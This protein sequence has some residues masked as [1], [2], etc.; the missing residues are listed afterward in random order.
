MDFVDRC[1]RAFEKFKAVC[2]DPDRHAIGVYRDLLTQV[3][4]TDYGNA[5]MIT[6]TT[7]PGEFRQRVPIKT[8]T[9]FEPYIDQI[10][11]GRRKVL[12]VD[13][14]IA[15]YTTSG[16]TGRPKRVPA[17]RHLRQ[18]YRGPALECQW[19]LYFTQLGIQ[20][21]EPTLVVDFSWDRHAVADVEGQ[22]IPEYSI[23]KRPSSL[24]GGDWTPPWYDDSGFVT[25][26]GETHVDGEIRR[27]VDALRKNP[28][29]LVAVNPSRLIHDTMYIVN[30][31]RR[32]AEALGDGQD[33]DRARAAL[34][35]IDG[36]PDA[37]SVLFPRLRMIVSWLSASA[38]L[39]SGTL[40]QLF[41]GARL[42]PFSTT[43][44]E[45]IVTL[46]V[47]GEPGSPLAVNQ[48]WYEFVPWKDLNSD[49]PVPPHDPTLC[50]D[51]LE[52]GQQYRLIM[53]QATGL[54]RYDTGDAYRVTGWFG[55]SPRLEF[56]GRVGSTSSMTGEKLTEGCI[57]AAVRSVTAVEG[58]ERFAMF[59]EPP[60]A[61]PPPVEPY[62]ILAIERALI[63]T[64]LTPAEFATRVDRALGDQN[65]EY[66]G[67]R[68][69]DEKTVIRLGRMRVLPV[70]DGAFA[71]FREELTSTGQVSPTQ[72]KHRVLHPRRS[73][74]TPEPPLQGWLFER[75]LPDIV[76]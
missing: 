3:A 49:E 32:I 25:P 33:A 42:M 18:R 6:L 73:I 56:V 63:P 48:G 15:F 69:G 62:Y 53:S 31:S 50:Y 2:A 11:N 7:P 26:R 30:N 46:P 51:Q 70:P 29:I 45:G 1:N 68:F 20:E 75:Y 52:V 37:G 5:H 19:G 61:G 38:G 71:S 28:V 47:D 55:K 76:R 60:Q 74:E 59:V 40:R 65:T 27:A 67:K 16:T 34:E 35:A 57:A 24:G 17:T 4:G 43:G 8:F 72:F 39:Y 23:T 14:P 44:T 54:L 58:N 12:T 9:G 41:P 66:G 36:R 64:N 13:D 21:Y 22:L 10:A